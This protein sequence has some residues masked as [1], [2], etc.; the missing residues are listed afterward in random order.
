MLG[1]VALKLLYIMMMII[2]SSI[3][4][5]VFFFWMLD[6][7]CLPFLST[8]PEESRFDMDLSTRPYR[9]MKYHQKSVSSVDFHP[10]R[11]LFASSASDGKVLIFHGRVYSDLLQNPLI[12]PLK[13]LRPHNHL[14]GSK[15]SQT[16]DKQECLFHPSQPWVFISCGNEIQLWTE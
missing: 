4:I 1:S 3:A 11:P 8:S 6:L 5:A 15:N 16:G 9:T 10:S 12:V 13:I 7:I 2:G 14:L